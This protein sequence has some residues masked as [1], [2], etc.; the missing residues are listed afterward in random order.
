[1]NTLNKSEIE[2]I[3][4]NICE[5]KY[6]KTPCLMVKGLPRNKFRHFILIF[7][8]HRNPVF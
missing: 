1:M 4:N 7:V 3:I 8:T 2:A 6:L 5:K